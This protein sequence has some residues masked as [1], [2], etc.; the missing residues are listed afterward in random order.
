MD[1]QC[2]GIDWGTV[3]IG[4]ALG[5][6][7]TRIASPLGVVGSVEAVLEMAKKEK[8]DRLVV[9]KPFHAHGQQRAENEPFE[10]FIAALEGRSGLPITL[11][12]ERFSSQSA[13]KLGVGKKRDGE[14]DAVAA[15]VILQSYFDK[16]PK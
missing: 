8:I 7:E 9:G 14:R 5:N 10:A 15:M 1:E 3:R 12:D 4:L 16:L 2:L 11:V 13:D 6:A